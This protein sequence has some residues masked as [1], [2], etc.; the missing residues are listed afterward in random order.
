M[1][2]APAVRISTLS[3]RNARGTR[4]PS[5]S[6]SP[7]APSVV[8]SPSGTKQR[9]HTPCLLGA[10]CPAQQLSPAQQALQEPPA[11]YAWLLVV[12]ESGMPVM[13]LRHG[14]LSPP[15]GATPS[16]AASQQ[17]PPGPVPLATQGLL[18]GLHTAAANAGVRIRLL[19]VAPPGGAAAAAAGSGEAAAPPPLLP[20]QLQRAASTPALQA[21]AVGAGTPSLAQAGPWAA[22]FALHH[23]L[24]FD[25][26]ACPADIHAA[27]QP[28][29]W[30]QQQ[31]AQR[32]ALAQA[33]AQPPAKAWRQRL[34]G[35]GAGAGAG[36]ATLPPLATPSTPAPKVSFFLF[37]NAWQ[38]C[39]P[40]TPL[41]QGE[42]NAAT[43]TPTSSWGTAGA[44][45]AAWAA[46]ASACA[47]LA[48]PSATAAARAF[49]CRLQSLLC[50]WLGGAGW[51]RLINDPN[52]RPLRLR[53][54]KLAPVVERLFSYWL[55]GVRA[56]EGGGGQGLLLPLL[57][58]SAAVWGE[59]AARQ[60]HACAPWATPSPP[61][62][63]Q[64]L[65]AAPP[66]PALPTPTAGLQCSLAPAAAPKPS[67]LLG[68]TC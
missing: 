12:N 20:P 38:L 55:T 16:A 17:P 51:W 52:S 23:A 60:R 58:P 42:G 49:L 8:G 50:L 34:G 46:H 19:T 24:T 35:A 2:S 59:E 41:L 4:L 1:Q 33:Q 56:E 14:V 61:T 27:L 53:L 7:R 11:L 67:L 64:V 43:P 68:R 13:S 44:P 31:L 21:A 26:F 40:P 3:P 54:A 9:L 45:A 30:R 62:T 15:S 6:G 65:A 5:D 39:C 48:L 63:T 29:A 10:S 32:Q 37:T 28:V 57:L 36:A 66:P 47:A 22:P 25:T 18:A